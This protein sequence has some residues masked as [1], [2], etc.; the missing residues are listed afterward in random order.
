M[1]EIKSNSTG[2]I[3]P[4][5]KLEVTDHFYPVYIKSEKYE[6]LL[7]VQ[8]HPCVKYWFQDKEVTMDR[9]IEILSSVK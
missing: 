4:S 7:V 3:N 6:K 2:V 9:L 1:L 8:S 5:V